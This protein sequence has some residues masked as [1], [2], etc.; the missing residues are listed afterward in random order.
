MYSAAYGTVHYK[1]PLK[2]FEISVEHSPRGF[3]LSRYCH[4]CTESDVKQYSL[5]HYFPESQVAHTPFP[6]RVPHPIV[7][8][9]TISS[10]IYCIY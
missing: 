1:E 10:M 6:Q 9:T 4:E 2:S 5:T 3:L 7:Q 8:K